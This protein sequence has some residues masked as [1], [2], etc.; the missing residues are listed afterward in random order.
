M[1][2]AA[3]IAVGMPAG[4]VVTFAGAAAPSGW[5]LAYGQAVSRTTYADLFNA[6]G[7]TYGTGDG[8][9]TFN[10]PDGRGRVG[11][12]KDNMGGTAAGRLTNSGTGNPSIDGTTLGATGG[13]DRHTLTTAQ[14]PSHT[15]S[16][17]AAA[18]TGGNS[19]AGGSG[20]G[21]PGSVATGSAGSDNAHPNCQPTI[22]FNLIIKT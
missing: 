19:A 3:L 17:S 4:T 7:T 18:T 16:N 9:T 6:I 15:H 13:V 22:V 21:Y 5:L 1:S 10:L 11:A 8:S 20:Y 12:G 14:M 2:K